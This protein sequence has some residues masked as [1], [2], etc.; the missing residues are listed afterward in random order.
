[1]GVSFFA[2]LL[3]AVCPPVLSQLRYSSEY[4]QDRINTDQTSFMLQNSG[5]AEYHCASEWTTATVQGYLNDTAVFQWHFRDGAKA[6]ARQV[7]YVGDIGKLTEFLTVN[8]TSDLED[9]QGKKIQPMTRDNPPVRVELWIGDFDSSAG[10]S[11]GILID[12]ACFDGQTIE[13]SQSYHFAPC[14]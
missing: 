6:F 3:C 5:T 10:Y 13:Y 12:K 4:T 8:K 9:K 7:E 14:K 2:L 11:T 1:M